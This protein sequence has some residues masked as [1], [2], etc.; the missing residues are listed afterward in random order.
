MK[1]KA[2]V[3]CDD[4]LVK[5]LVLWRN[6]FGAHVSGKQTIKKTLPDGALPTQEQ[7]FKLCDRALNIY[8]R[9]RSLFRAD[10][11]VNTLGEKGST[12]SVFRLLRAGLTAGRK[13]AN[14]AAERLLKS[15]RSGNQA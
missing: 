10:F 15:T 13:E 12:E 7:A 11:I 4:P 9:Y 3:S 1:D 8:N 2:E 14:E 5:K 6:N